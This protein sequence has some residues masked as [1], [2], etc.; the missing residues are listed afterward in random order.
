[1]QIESHRITGNLT[2]YKKPDIVAQIE[3]EYPEM[4]KESY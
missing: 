1:M 3:R 4:T 2:V